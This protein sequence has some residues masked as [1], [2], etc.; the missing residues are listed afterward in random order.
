MVALLDVTST[1]DGAPGGVG[2]W[3]SP[4]PKTSYSCREYPCLASDRQRCVP[5]IR[6]KRPSPLTV[7]S[8]TP[9][10]PVVVEEMVAQVAWSLE[11]S[12]RYAVAQDRSHC[13]RTREMC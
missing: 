6:T 2:G 9:P 12:M 4:L 13:S 10:S 7:R 11:V 1:S 5:N 8:S 3:L